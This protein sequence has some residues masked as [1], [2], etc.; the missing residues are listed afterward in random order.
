MFKERTTAQSSNLFSL[1]QELIRPPITYIFPVNPNN[2]SISGGHNIKTH[3]I[4]GRDGAIY[5]NLGRSAKTI[6]LN[7]SLHRGYSYKNRQSYDMDQLVQDLQQFADAKTV[8]TLAGV[9]ANFTGAINVIVPQN[10]LTFKADRPKTLDYSL[11]LNE[12]TDFSIGV[13]KVNNNLVSS[14]DAANKFNQAARRAILR[15]G[16]TA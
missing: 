5:Q 3:I 1:V 11:T 7:G 14:Q 16:I 15:R 12:W 4:S 13:G 6:T 2:C 8:F 10:A 9:F